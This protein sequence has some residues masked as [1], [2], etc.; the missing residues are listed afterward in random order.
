MIDN[1]T[2]NS[3]ELILF[4]LQG[5]VLLNPHFCVESQF[6][7]RL[8]GMMLENFLSE[9]LSNVTIEVL[10]GEVRVLVPAVEG[11]P[12][13]VDHKEGE[14]QAEEPAQNEAWKVV[15]LSNRAEIAN[16]SCHS[17]EGEDNFLAHGEC[18][19]EDSNEAKDLK[20]RSVVL[21]EGESMALPSGTFHSVVTTSATPSSYMYT[22]VNTTIQKQITGSTN[23]E[24]SG[25]PKP[26]NIC[27]NHVTEDYF[28]RTSKK[29][30]MASESKDCKTKL[31]ETKPSIHTPDGDKNVQSYQ[32]ESGARGVVC[33]MPTVLDFVRFVRLKLAAFK[34]SARL[35]RDACRY[36]VAGIP[37]DVAR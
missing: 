34:R 29:T 8:P 31:D 33:G 15:H 6:L 16:A 17:Q 19:P 1:L 27:S 35:L 36:I 11:G 24:R 20:V 28:T 21:R 2:V 7:L 22:F 13:S 3:P 37:M 18:F 23:D 25:T 12:A 32:Q 9:D 4:I 30:K 10:H 5:E 14:E 26:T